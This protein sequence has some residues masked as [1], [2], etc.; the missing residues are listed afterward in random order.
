MIY[1]KESHRKVLSIT[2]NDPNYITISE[3]IKIC[4][5]E[6]KDSESQNCEVYFYVADSTFADTAYKLDS[7]TVRADY[8][9][10]D[11]HIKIV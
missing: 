5:E 9:Q 2:W 8:Q 11:I 1:N 10:I 4:I 3:I 7:I 6:C